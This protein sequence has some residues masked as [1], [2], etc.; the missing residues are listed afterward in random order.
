MK[1]NDEKKNKQTQEKELGTNKQYL[2]LITYVDN[3]SVGNRIDCNP[4]S[5]SEDLKSRNI[6]LEQNRDQIRIGVTGQSI[7]EIW[8]WAWWVVIHCHVLPMLAQCIL[9]V[10]HV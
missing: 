3:E 6:I 4:V 9:N 5:V 2:H 7:S 8:L 1:T 10:A